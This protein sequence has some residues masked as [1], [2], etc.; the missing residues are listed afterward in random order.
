MNILGESVV[1][2]NIRKNKRTQ[3]RERKYNFLKYLRVVRYYIKKKY[4]LS[5]AELDMLLYLYDVPVFKKDDFN[6]F[7]PSMSW[8]KKRFYQMINE[9]YIK[10]WR[11]GGI[12]NARSKM[13]ELTQKSKTICLSMYK[14]LLKEEKITEDPRINPVFKNNSYTDKMYRKII[15]KMNAK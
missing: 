7:Q 10:E 12:K 14:K 13:Y 3:P 15:Q 11:G 6:V 1:K 5:S 4:G 8:N 9:G 2:T